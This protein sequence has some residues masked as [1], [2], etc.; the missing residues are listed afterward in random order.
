MSHQTTV[1][2]DQFPQ[3][4]KKRG[5]RAKCRQMGMSFTLGD[6][7]VT[8]KWAQTGKDPLTLP[9]FV[10]FMSHQ[11]IFMLKV[12]KFIEVL[13]YQEEK[14]REECL[15]QHLC[16]LQIR[17]KIHPAKGLLWK[18]P[19][20]VLTN[21][22]AVKINL[23]HKQEN[24]I[25]MDLTET[26]KMVRLKLSNCHHYNQ[27]DFFKCRNS[28][29]ALMFMCMRGING[30]S[31]P[32]G[33]RRRSSVAL[34]QAPSLMLDGSFLT[35]YHSCADS[36][37]IDM[38]QLVREQDHI[39][40]SCCFFLNMR[41]NLKFFSFVVCLHILSNCFHQQCHEIKDQQCSFPWPPPRWW[42]LSVWLGKQYKALNGF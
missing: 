27:Y 18:W 3:C 37:T 23:I 21:Y 41:I 24:W 4:R 28:P 15:F 5:C 10:Q 32:P 9:R 29:D 1:S 35:R 2:E 31:V 11:V 38:A 19:D 16:T 39:S 6:L 36:S 34:L 8:E 26:W 12:T 14:E 17:P 25:K 22:N 33:E 20:S 7:K 42:C 30:I 40:T 13:V